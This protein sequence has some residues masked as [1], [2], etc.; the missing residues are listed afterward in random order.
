M[1]FLKYLY[2]QVYLYLYFICIWMNEGG[3]PCQHEVWWW[4]SH[5]GLRKRCVFWDKGE[6]NPDKLKLWFTISFFYLKISKMMTCLQSTRRHVELVYLLIHPPVGHYDDKPWWRWRW[7]LQWQ[8][9]QWQRWRYQ[10]TWHS[11][12]VTMELRPASASLSLDQKII[13]LVTNVM[14]I[15]RIIITVIITKAEGALSKTLP[16]YFLPNPSIQSHFNIMIIF[17]SISW[18]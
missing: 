9:W 15:T 8:R 6:R 14:T 2:L 18:L 13:K 16:R 1:K 5:G 10:S 7:R 4:V 3:S 11:R 17:S 12:E